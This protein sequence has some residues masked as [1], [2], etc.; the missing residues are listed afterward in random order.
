MQS[1]SH[2]IQTQSLFTTKRLRQTNAIRLSQ[3]KF[4]GKEYAEHQILDKIY[5]REPAKNKRIWQN[6]KQYNPLGVWPGVIT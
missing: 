5:C 3:S 1:P 6:A 4:N 2:G